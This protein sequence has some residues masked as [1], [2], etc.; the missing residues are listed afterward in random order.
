MLVLL[1]LDLEGIIEV[2]TDPKGGFVSL[3]VSSS[4]D[5]VLCVYTP[6]GYSS[7]GQLTRGRFAEGLQNYTWRLS[8]CYG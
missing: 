2:D 7:R 8:L 6:S 3:K 5:R 4:S 1:H